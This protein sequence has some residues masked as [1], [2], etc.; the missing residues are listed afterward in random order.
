MDY[1]L[2]RAVCSEDARRVIT[3]LRNGA[4][5]DKVTHKGHTALHAA[6]MV[7]R[8][9]FVP[10]LLH[11]GAKVNARDKLGQ[12]PLHYVRSVQSAAA[13]LK[14]GADVHAEDSMGR[15][16]LNCFCFATN[17][18]FDI[19]DLLLE[20]NAKVNSKDIHGNTPLHGA[21]MRKDATRLVLCLLKHGA[22]VNATN[23]DLCTPF[24]CA[25]RWGSCIGNLRA[26]KTYGAIVDAVDIDG[27]TALHYASSHNFS[28][29]CDV[30]ELISVLLKSGANINLRD[31]NGYTSLHSAASQGFEENVLALLQHGACRIRKEEK[32]IRGGKTAMELAL[33]NKHAGTIT[34][35]LAHGVKICQ[36]IEAF[37]PGP[38]LDIIELLAWNGFSDA[39]TLLCLYI[40]QEQR[41]EKNDETRQ[42]RKRKYS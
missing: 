5:V 38:V 18:S 23:Q 8:R 24:H 20:H 14:G 25:T 29:T 13:L 41:Q 12:S 42:M 10:I 35:L 2:H 4:N 36:D 7:T 22:Q 33:C 9:C 26:L 34:I 6:A 1:E 21:A 17:S 15:T 40:R 32:T 39:S 31:N 30:S 27:R 28:S 11:F 3:L 19:C 37:A 16:P